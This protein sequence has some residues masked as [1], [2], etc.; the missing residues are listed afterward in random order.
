[1]SASVE[2]PAPAPVSTA[3]P[4]G[5]PPLPLLTVLNFFNYMDRQVVYGMA[6][7]IIDTFHLSQFQF[8]WLAFVNLMVFALASVVS[9]RIA[10]RVG[11]RKVIF[12]GVLV[13]SLATIGSALSHSFWSLLVC[14]ALVGV[15]EGAYGPSANAL[16]CAAAPPEKRGR[17]LGIYNIG[18]AF[19][20]TTGLVLGNGLSRTMDWH[21]VFWIAGGPSIL[22]AA[23]AAFVAAPER[24]ARPEALPARAYL[25]A[26]TFLLALAGG[27]LATFGASALVVWCQK[28]ITVEKG[29]S[30]MLGNVYMLGVG[31]V[32]GI[33]G[34]VAG[35]Y[36]GDALN[37]RAPGGHARAIGLSLLVATPF[38]VVSLLVTNVPAFM[39]LT[40]V[41]VFL[42][43]V[44]NGPSAAVIDELGPPQFAATLQGVSLF[45]VHVLGNAPAGAVTG[46]IADRS[47]VA[48]ALQAAILAF[49][50]SGVLFM[51]VA[52]R[53]R[54]AKDALP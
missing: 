30:G 21:T 2:L 39:V 46:W 1:M 41:S 49:A 10:D 17:A 4:R 50:V 38:G 44:Y 6:D 11:P 54:R 13:W 47:T 53:Q 34:V 31:L 19:G 15:G 28:L 8:G 32:C 18:M 51:I 52:S 5:I 25:L 37:R 43:S 42:F 9:G 40:A 3:R 36:L 20:A 22:L 23:C 48:F 24:L 33:G 14:R 26:P 35:G 7:K 27:I 29:L 12:A 45:W 16:L